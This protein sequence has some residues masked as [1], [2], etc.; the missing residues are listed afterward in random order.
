MNNKNDNYA[1]WEAMQSG[2]ALEMD[3]DDDDDDEYY[4]DEEEE[5]EDDGVVFETETEMKQ[6]TLVAGDGAG[7]AGNVTETKQKRRWFGWLRRR[8]GNDVSR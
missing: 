3:D 1:Y 4:D 7:D 6:I 8:G 2:A 5:F